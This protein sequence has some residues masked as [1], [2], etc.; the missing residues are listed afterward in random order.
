[1]NEFLLTGAT[2]FLGSWLLEQLLEETDGFINIL[3]RGKN[4]QDSTQRFYDT[5]L[6]NRCSKRL[7]D[8]CQ[9][10]VKILNG[11]IENDRLLLSDNEYLLL[12]RNLD[13]IFH[14]AAV[15]G[16]DLDLDSARKI[17][18]GGTSNILK[19]AVSCRRLRKL[20]YISTTFIAGDHKGFFSEDNFNLGQKFNNNY[21]KSKYEAEELIIEGSKEKEYS[22]F[23]Y[24][25][26]IVIG[27]YEFGESTN[28]K[29]FYEP[30]RLFSRNLLQKVPANHDTLHNLI[31]VDI[32]A[33]S[34]VL[35]SLKEELGGIYHIISQNNIHSGSFFEEAAAF[36]NFKLPKFVPLEEFD[37]S[38]LTPVQLKLVTPFL[39]YFN[40][41][42]LFTN[43]KTKDILLKNYFVMPEVDVFFYKRI[44]MYCDKVG[45]IRR[46]S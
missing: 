46:S 43:K 17:N 1:M 23:I 18:V 10:R 13:E 15:T 30:L 42:S 38:E 16:F 14:C 34:I 21:E 20:H 19:L 31:P 24:R 33:K 5:V 2:G 39:P 44:F 35:L 36:F 41:K 12:C 25:P 22:L 4:I 8:L 6:H 11:T 28:F 27:S 9:S 7:K 29:M 37:L 26:S 32:A 45:F 40:Y 3:V